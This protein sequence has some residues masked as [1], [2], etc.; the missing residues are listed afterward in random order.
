[1]DGWMNEWKCFDVRQK[2]NEWMWCD[3]M[4][5]EEGNR[6]AEIHVT[7][8][9][10]AVQF[11]LSISH[12]TLLCFLA[13]TKALKLM[14]SPIHFQLLS[15]FSVLFYSVLFPS[16]L[17]SGGRSNRMRD[18]CVCVCEK[19]AHLCWCLSICNLSTLTPTL[20]LQSLGA[21]N[22]MLPPHE[23]CFSVHHSHWWHNQPAS[24]PAN[25][26]QVAISISPPQALIS[27][28]LQATWG[29]RNHLWAADSFIHLL[30]LCVHYYYYYYFWGAR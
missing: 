26:P 14:W 2:I 15:F 27:K 9:C 20:T 23:H 8:N 28:L 5:W 4:C 3:V 25:I 12:T 16:F 6:A 21:S 18:S 30:A 22:F 17:P 1:M 7:V 11:S 13:H 29:M 19:P 10:Q 24:Q